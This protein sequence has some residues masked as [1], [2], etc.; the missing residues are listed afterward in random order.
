MHP[1]KRQSVIG[2]LG[3]FLAVVLVSI[4]S[5]HAGSAPIVLDHTP[6][7]GDALSVDGVVQ[8][9]F[10]EP[11]DHRSVET[12]WDLA[13]DVDGSFVWVDDRTVRFEPASAWERAVEY[14]LTLRS[15]ARSSAGVEM[16][17]PFSFS[18]RTVGFLTVIQALP[19]A[20][21][22][23]IATSSDLFLM[24]SQPVVPLL[25]LSDPGRQDL[26][27]PLQLEPTVA[28]HGE[29]LNT[30][31]YVFTPSEPLRGGTRYTAVV[32][33]GLTGTQG[34]M[35][36]E[37][38][39]WQFT[40]ERPKVVRISPSDGQTHVSVEPSIRITFNM[41]VCLDAVASGFSLKRIGLLGELLSPRISGSWTMEGSTVVF[42]P[43][44]R[45][46]FDQPYAF[47]LDAGVPS[48][49][50]GAGTQTS[51]RI[52]F[53]TVPRPKLVRVTP[54]DGEQDVYP[55]TSLVLT[56]NTPI[57]PDT[58]L[59]NVSISPEPEPGTVSGYYRS[60]D[61]AYVVWFDCGPS[62]SYDIRIAPGIEDPYGN[63][64]EEETR[65]RFRTRPL[66]PGAWLQVPDRVS[67]AS[68]YQPTRLFIAH[69]N[70]NSVSLTLHRLSLDE[71]FHAT[72][73]W[74]KYTP[75]EKT[76]V[77]TW[78][79]EVEGAL[80]Q[81]AV[82]PV[83]LSPD[84]EPLP[85]GVYLIDVDGPEAFW[86]R[87]QHRHLLLVSPVSVTLKTTGEETIV[88]ACDLSSGA[89][90]PGLILRAY[91]ADGQ[92]TEVSITDRDGIGTFS[93]TDLYGWRGITVAAASPFVLGSSQWTRG[94]SAWDFGYSFQS[95][96]EIRLFLDTDRPLY[97]PGHTVFFRGVLRKEQ[98]VAYTLPD[99]EEVMVTV[100]DAAGTQILELT[101][102][103]DGHGTFSG[104][105]L[106]GE[107][108]AIG[109]YRM[110]VTAAGIRQSATFDV[111]AYRAP[112]FRV[113]VHPERSET[114][115]GE[116]L[117]TDISVQYYFGAPVSDA[118]IDWSLFTESF[119]FSA[120][121]LGRYT[122]SDRDD[123]WSC[124][125]C[126]WM[127]P[128]PRRS[129]LQG[130]TAT[131]ASGHA[132]VE[133]SA[134]DLRE[135]DADEPT[136]SRT[137]TLEATVR[138]ADDQVI[139]GRERIVV[140]A[141]RFYAGLA[142]SGSIA[143]AGSRVDADV[144]TVD[145]AGAAVPEQP[146]EYQVLHREWINT[147][148]DDGDGGGQW[149][150][151]VQDTEVETGS[152]T[153][154]TEGRGRF[155]FVPAQGGTHK[156]L[157]V[158]ID[159]Q[160]NAARASV[161][162]W[163]SGSET[164]SWRRTN[165]DALTLISDQ[166][167]YQVGDTARILIPS[168]YAE[169]HYALVTVE[170]GGV[171]SR[172]VH[173]FESNSPVI[174]LSIT[175][176]HIPNI[177]VGVVL[178]QGLEAAERA[179]DGGEP[180]AE[181]K[182]GYAVLTVSPAP[183]Q[184]QLDLQP[185]E[186]APQPGTE[187]TYRL[188]IT[189]DAGDPVRA[190]VAFDLVDAA[191][192]ALKP[193][194]PNA[195][196]DAFYSPRGLGVS[197]AGGLTVSLNRL[198]AQQ[199]EEYDDILGRGPQ[200][201]TETSGMEPPSV[202]EMSEDLSVATLT[203]KRSAA[204]QLPE[205]VA[206]REEF[207]DT[208]FWSGSVVT[209]ADGFAEILVRLPDNLTTW[210][211]RAVGVTTDTQVGESTGTLLVTKPLLIRPVTPR[212]LVVGDRVRLTANVS[213]QTSEAL[214]TEVLLAQ[215]GLSL[216]GPSAQTV[217]IPAHGEVSVVW[218]GVVSDVPTVDLAFSAVSGEFS[219]AARP[220]LTTG[221][222]GSLRVFR[223]TSPDTVGTAGQLDE[224]GTRTERIHVSEFV[225][226]SRSTL[227]VQLETSLAAAMQTGLRYLEHFEYECTEQVISRFLPNV[228]THRAL[229]SLGLDRPAWGDRLPE[230]VTEGVEKLASRQNSDGGWG[231]WD[232]TRSNRHVSAYAVFGLLHAERSG[233]VLP[234][235]L[236]ARGL[237]FLVQSLVSSEALGSF[238]TADRQAWLVYVLSEAGR[239]EDALPAARSL[240]DA[241]AQL[242]QY[243]RAWLA[244][245]LSLCGDETG[246]IDTLLSDLYSA[247]ILSATGAHWEEA[248]HDR[249]AMNT[250]T[251]STAV[252]LDAL[253][254]LD[255]DQP[256]LPNVVRWLMVARR[257][258][259]WE[260]TQE[261]AWAL[262]AL[263]D[264]MTATGELDSSYA[265]AVSLNEIP[266][267]EGLASDGTETDPLVVTRTIDPSWLGQTHRLSIERS[268]GTGRL[269]Y[270][271]HLTSYL[272]AQRIEPLH[273]GITVQ[274]EYL[275]C[276]PEDGCTPVES[277][278]AGDELLV[279]LTLIAPS[280]L[281]YVVL[282]DP[283][284]AG[285]EAI[286][287]SLATTGLAA[288]APR[289]LRESQQDRSWF[290]WWW[291]RWYVRSEFRDEKTVLFADS[292][293]AGTYTFEYVLRAVTV[294]EFGV[295]PATAQEFYFPEVFGR[296]AG[297]TLSVTPS[298]EL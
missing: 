260:T 166:T 211:A 266:L 218:W 114:V 170:R 190:A 17:D 156:V 192:L 206:L 68:S 155:S 112:E 63:R 196:L 239:T 90:I 51:Q 40:T 168:P 212:F 144:V 46:A 128:I 224:E 169:P 22:D 231:W 228:L 163:V 4:G 31:V 178:F 136:G 277:V 8:L 180:A 137:V 88:W 77:R 282:E 9:R 292:L 217:I 124:W 117:R 286:D 107:E 264:W 272:P 11:M 249:W 69:R 274:R 195:I 105:V 182:V 134:E 276:S 7:R 47:T 225:D 173:L 103:V 145:W 154:D 210:T 74:Y 194:T 164:V 37:P 139:S 106:L 268:E 33:A 283:F 287:P 237:E 275:S 39:R 140:H 159:E 280:D 91:D 120:A 191:V 250:D 273:R 43:D 92:S 200:T 183:K 271:A 186:T 30:S 56:F 12:A 143:R 101:C 241:R 235:G 253:V 259:V 193:R 149:T 174:D 81:V 213:N 129:V 131:D 257:G 26:P 205:G 87:W 160:G 64:I 108:A 113:S 76:V 98:D 179:A 125:S 73:D 45:L 13:P 35:L 122:F 27:H 84:D 104:T 82:T 288:S 14:N 148:E 279:R 115:A 261:T 270:T 28:G 248:Q 132:L 65:V 167:T 85:P 54:Q 53:E 130:S 3:V 25:S 29:W 245:S 172:T 16:D 153:T 78:T 75:E 158:G 214:E 208:A 32:P 262:I 152:L 284:P 246:A 116:R 97:R 233:F 209:D 244:L 6:T 34:E 223:Y 123:P 222:D 258:G 242:S 133:I 58:V 66:D 267:A 100:R 185:S 121:H 67:T 138:G 285:C 141:A 142:V 1:I 62:R 147:Y 290:S 50:G 198:V 234:N 278:T 202:A 59:E 207:L 146:L 99:V 240:F 176:D 24:F 79:V 189:D 293:P 294:G 83:S 102:P 187:M 118:Q 95:G 93:G 150:W 19:A 197:T 44:S 298:G 10:S 2:G 42:T 219:D 161:F 38:V 227:R 255:P 236:L 57:D 151:T 203:S 243:A 281:Y 20:D 80:D 297:R 229:T 162:V 184:L 215:T 175:E 49:A 289:W 165:D 269:Y 204:D 256:L 296:S 52:R 135:N 71:Y 5:V 127:P 216:E 89:P 119:H 265:F 220:R 60:W 72:S 188:R 230:L 94:I 181:F 221:P 110:E 295:L 177:Y 226:P 61:R 199:A 263:T 247:A 15:S 55:Y 70:T 18:F 232:Q 291:W 21:A 238:H 23:E 111:A 109:R 96:Q 171:L 41:P 86:N 157:L 36:V 252:I 48:A 126:W 201:E 254:R 251:R